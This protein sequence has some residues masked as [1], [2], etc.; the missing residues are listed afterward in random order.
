MALGLNDL[1]SPKGLLEAYLF[2]KKTPELSQ[3]ELEARVTEWLNQSYGALAGIP[4]ASI[5]EATRYYV[6]YRA[7]ES[8]Y[9]RMLID[10]TKV[11]LN[12]G[13]S[14]VENSDA[15]LKEFGRLR[16]H[17]RAAYESLLPSDPTPKR[18]SM[19]VDV[20]VKV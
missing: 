10:P 2:P 7:Y 4:S 9:Q 12:S 16:D 20:R 5:D 11:T 6:Y 8:V 17:Y 19:S 15:K 1:I 13:K 14:N 3:T 18:R